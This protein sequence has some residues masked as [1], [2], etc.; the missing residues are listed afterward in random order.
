MIQLIDVSKDY[1]EGENAVHA[2]REL[3]LEIAAGVFVAIV[4][5]SGSGKTTLLHLIGAL[6]RPSSGR[7]QVAGLDLGAM[8]DAERTRFRR[9]RIGFVFQFFNLLPTLTAVEN[10]ALPAELAG[11]PARKARLRAEELLER[12]Q[13]AHR[14]QH[15]PDSLSGGEMQRVAIARALMMDPPLVVAD[16]PTG[17]LDSKT[18][19]AVLD[20]LCAAVGAER[21]LVLVT[22]DPS[23]AARADRTITMSDGRVVADSAPV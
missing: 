17:N 11:Q 20:L 21:T 7:V 23:V 9:T 4:G 5:A 3:S 13:L 22:H 8:T 2:V 18:G 6:D 15:R 14:K 12:V 1:G 19:H 10:V 16:E